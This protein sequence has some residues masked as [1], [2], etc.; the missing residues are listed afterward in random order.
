ME[1]LENTTEFPFG[2]CH[3]CAGIRALFEYDPLLND[4]ERGLLVAGHRDTYEKKLGEIASQLGFGDEFRG[5]GARKRKVKTELG[6][7]LGSEAPFWV[8][9]WE[10]LPEEKRPPQWWESTTRKK[11]RGRRR[12]GKL[13]LDDGTVAWL[14]GILERWLDHLRD[15]EVDEIERLHDQELEGE[16]TGL[17]SHLARHI[18]RDTLGQRLANVVQRIEQRYEELSPG[19]LLLDKE[20]GRRRNRLAVEILSVA[21]DGLIDADQLAEKA[22]RG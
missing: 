18:P 9:P 21:L 3:D 1:N 8:W 5:R 22:R 20:W 11:V 10:S 14:V 17:R 13:G 4:P 12:P 6:R 2:R 7:R 19:G 15:E 16:D